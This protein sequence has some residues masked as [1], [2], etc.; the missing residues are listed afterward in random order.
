MLDRFIRRFAVME[1]AQRGLEVLLT[2]CSYIE[3][4]LSPSSRHFVC[5]ASP[6]VVSVYSLHRGSANYHITQVAQMLAG[7]AYLDE[8]RHRHKPDRRYRLG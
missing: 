8:L 1:A 3:P 5:H 2:V 7:L 6:V 4:V